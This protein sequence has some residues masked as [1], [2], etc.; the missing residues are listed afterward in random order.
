[1]G[2]E[3]VVD[4]VQVAVNHIH[5]THIQ[6]V[7]AREVVDEVVEVVD[8]LHHLSQPRQ[9]ISLLRVSSQACLVISRQ[10]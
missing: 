1:M 8:S 3:V 9:Q 5:L 10:I 4:E 7:E 2:D 6:M